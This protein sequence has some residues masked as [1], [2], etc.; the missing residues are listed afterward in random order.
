[1]KLI[2]STSTVALAGL[3]LLIPASYGSKQ[4]RCPRGDP[5]SK[6]DVLRYSK[7]HSESFNLDEYPLT[8][9]GKK[10]SSTYFTSPLGAPLTYA[11]AY[12]IQVYDNPPQ[13]QLAQYNM[14]V[15]TV[16]TLEESQ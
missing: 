16:C 1:M 8:P 11:A 15:W 14:G 2:S 4:Y 13:Y 10:Y 6:E 9:A 12:V 7:G 5:I 3:L